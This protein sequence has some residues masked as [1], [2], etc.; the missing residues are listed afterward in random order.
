[1]NR[2]DGSKRF[3]RRDFI[4]TMGMAASASLLPDTFLS[5]AKK[6]TPNIVLI[7]VDDMGWTDTGCTGSRYYETPNI[8][9]LCAQGMKF[10]QAYAASAVCSPTRASLLTGR[11]PARIGITDWIHHVH[12]LA[13]TA[14][15]TKKNPEG[16]QT[17]PKRKL[18]TPYNK[19]WLEHDEVTI[20]ELLKPRSYST[21]HVGKWH[22]GFEQWFPGTQGFDYN[23]GGCQ[24]G[25]PP[26]YFDPYERKLKKNRKRSIP[27]LEPRQAGEYLT[28]READEAVHFIRK[29]KDQPFFLYLSHYAVHTPIRAKEALRKKYL[30]KQK[31]NHTSPTY[32]AMVE[33]V[34]QAVGKVRAVLKELNLEDNTLIIFTSDNGGASHVGVDGGKATD[35]SPLRK[36]KGYPYEGG[37][38][39]PLIVTWPGKIKAGQVNDTP[40]SSVD[41]LPTICD[42]LEIKPPAGRHI[43]GLS[44]MPL[45]TGTKAGDIFHRDTLYWHFPHYWWGGR[46]KPY[47]IIRQKKWKLIHHYEGNRLELFNLKDDIGE[48]VNLAKKMPELAKQLAKKLSLW[49]QEAGAKLPI[50]K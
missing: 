37:I 35:N 23:I 32:A 21:C 14:I 4:K 3:N 49:L 47:S 31:T 16:F 9:E 27:T 42:A 40:V 29:H 34:D 33:S 8:D 30:G 22:L 43:D 15:A 5:G 36:G 20:P 24:Y 13:P 7:L 18:K 19:F 45:L 26:D 11:Y 25:Q 46:I 39:V 44:L 6:R 38:R 10:N 41:I 17:F 12:P 28:D 48:T 1:M 2:P 50:P